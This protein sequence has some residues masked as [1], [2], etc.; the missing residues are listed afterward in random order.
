MFRNPVLLYL[1]KIW[2]ILKNNFV[3]KKAN[4][5]LCWQRMNLWQRIKFIISLSFDIVLTVSIIYFSA[6]YF[7]GSYSISVNDVRIPLDHR[8]TLEGKDDNKNGIRD[9]IDELIDVLAKKK[10]YNNQQVKSLQQQARI[11]QREILVDL[12]SE[13]EIDAVADGVSRSINCL[14]RNFKERDRDSVFNEIRDS[15][16]NTRQR[17]QASAEFD[18]AMSGS[19]SGLADGNTCE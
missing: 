10:N 13:K 14:F 17:I 16:F 4:G 8:L 12:N 2:N 15:T 3:A 19:G 18:H 11:E 7:F 5:L 6:W 1:L 9:D